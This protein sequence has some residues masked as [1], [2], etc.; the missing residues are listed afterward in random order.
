MIRFHPNFL[1]S[2]RAMVVY[3]GKLQPDNDIENCIFCHAV[4]GADGTPV[5]YDNPQHFCGSCHSRAAVNIDCFECHG[6]ALPKQ[7]SALTPGN[8]FA[9]LP[10]PPRTAGSARP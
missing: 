4:I 5:R 3:Q 6:S 10:P 8:G 2:Y 9:A 7:E 1:L